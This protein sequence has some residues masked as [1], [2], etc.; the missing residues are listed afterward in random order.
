MIFALYAHAKIKFGGHRQ[1]L[2]I[3]NVSA[4]AHAHNIGNAYSAYY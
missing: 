4:L 1:Y 3:I 2:P